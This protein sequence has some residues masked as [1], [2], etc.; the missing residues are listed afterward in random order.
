MHTLDT[1]HLFAR[2]DTHVVGTCP[3]R[4][5]REFLAQTLANH[6][7][8]KRTV[9]TN[10]KLVYPAIHN[11][12]EIGS[13][14]SGS[15]ISPRSSSVRKENDDLCLVEFEAVLHFEFAPNGRVVNSDLYF[16]QTEP[17]A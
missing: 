17:K 3:T 16:Q 10:E 9:T 8:W 7:I 6:R 2:E 11:Q 12:Q 5:G 15:S 4:K 1:G 14:K 13:K